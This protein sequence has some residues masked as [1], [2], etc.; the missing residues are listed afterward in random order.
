MYAL[1]SVYC[2]GIHPRRY[3]HWATSEGD[4]TCVNGLE[5]CFQMYKYMTTD[6]WLSFI[7][8]HLAM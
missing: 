7:H 6:N 3:V 5:L 2:D 1:I 8:C 4:G